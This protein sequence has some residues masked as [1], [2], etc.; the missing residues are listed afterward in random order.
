M[1]NGFIKLQPSGTE[2]ESLNLPSLVV[3]I[4][5]DDDDEA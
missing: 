4:G 1:E 3:K 5:G 2:L